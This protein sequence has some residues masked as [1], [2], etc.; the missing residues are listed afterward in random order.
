MGNC[1]SRHS[2][3]EDKIRK[4]NSKTSIKKCSDSDASEQSNVNDVHE[5]ANASPNDAA[6]AEEETSI[7]KDGD[8]S[9]VSNVN[10][11]NDDAKTGEISVKNDNFE[12]NFNIVNEDGPT[13]LNNAAKVGDVDKCHELLLGGADV[14]STDENNSTPLM[15]AAQEGHLPVCVLLVQSGADIHKTDHE[16]GRTALWQAAS[17]SSSSFIAK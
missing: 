4:Y 17:S 15:W 11:V 14:N 2:S 8:V 10:I 13:N 5:D 6:E 3:D 7:K 1:W 12:S 9:V 16:D